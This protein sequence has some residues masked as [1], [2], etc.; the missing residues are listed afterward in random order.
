MADD[1]APHPP[2]I[3]TPLSGN[4]KSHTT[5]PLAVKV[6]IVVHTLTGG[7][8]RARPT[9]NGAPVRGDARHVIESQSGYNVAPITVETNAGNNDL[10]ILEEF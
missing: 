8:E 1:P 3:W 9:V 2:T 5:S 7:P 10:V 4:G 6:T